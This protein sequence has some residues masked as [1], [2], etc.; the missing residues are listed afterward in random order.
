VRLTIDGELG[1]ETSGI[2]VATAI[3]FM[4]VVT[5]AQLE[6]DDFHLRRVS[7]AHGP[8]VRELGDGVRHVVEDELNGPRLVEKLN[9]AIERKRDRLTFRPVE[10]LE[11]RWPFASPQATAPPAL[12]GAEAAAA[13]P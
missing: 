6:I 1:M 10:L 13:I 9:R 8:I 5:A 4:P 11:A 3:A 12:T 2:G 7:N